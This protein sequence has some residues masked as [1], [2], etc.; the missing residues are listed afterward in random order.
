MQILYFGGR[1]KLGYPGKKALGGEERTNK[2]NR[3][4]PSRLESNLD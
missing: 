1:G 4:L 3:H 2:R